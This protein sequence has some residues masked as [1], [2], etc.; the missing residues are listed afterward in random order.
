VSPLSRLGLALALTLG[1]SLSQA[2]PT[3][4]FGVFGDT[5]YSDFERR[6]LPLTLEDMGQA[7]IAFAI[8]DG[9]IKNGQSH[10]EDGLYDDIHKVFN[11]SSVP[12]IYVPGDNEWTDCSRTS[13][14]GYDQMERLA[15]LRR[16]FFSAPRS[17]GQQHLALE[18]Q[19]AYPENLRWVAGPVQFVTLN[20]PGYDNNAR[21]PADF[22]PRNQANLQWLGQAFAQAR[23]K[24]LK[25]LVLIIQANPWIE[26]DNEG[27]TKPGFK[28]FFEQ[29]R[30]ETADFPGQV[31]L[32]HGDT[33]SMQ[34]N[35]PL[36]D[37]KSRKVVE[38]FTRVETYGAPFL[39]WIRVVVDEDDARLFRFEPKPW[40]NR[41]NGPL[42]Q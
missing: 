9:D 16:V 31:L 30:R 17:L 4:T 10:C 37:R 8:H 26:A 34:I 35:Q 15:H 24:H 12:L 19:E 1:S 42:G 20:M 27:A 5:P 21:N 40:N 29:L 23:E 2:A 22:V 39:G 32:V 7:G 6:Q 33:H 25:G 3:L 14:G 11:A 36:R 41:N 18:Q 28:D 38:N 13:A